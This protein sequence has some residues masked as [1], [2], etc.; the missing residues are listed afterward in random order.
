MF[1]STRIDLIVDR[2]DDEVVGALGAFRD[3]RHR[4]WFLDAGANLEP[5]A[6]WLPTNPKG[7]ALS[8]F[9]GRVKKA[10]NTGLSEPV[11][12]PRRSAR[13]R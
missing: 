11:W 9:L 10:I 4:T 8:E 13:S 1:A 3:P 5:F 6:S 7:I 2:T 12:V